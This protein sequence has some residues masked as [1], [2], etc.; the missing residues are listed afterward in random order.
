MARMRGDRWF[1]YPTREDYG[2]PA[3]LGISY[4]AVFFESEGRKLHGWFFAATTTTPKGTVIHCHGNGGNITGHFD[5]ISWMPAHGW[6]VLCFDYQG[7]GRSE[8][9]PSRPGTIV[10]A[11]AAIDYVKS[12][13]DVDE[14]RLVLSGQSLGGAVS[15]VVAAERDDLRGVAIEGAFS[16]Y[17]GAAYYVCKRSWLL[18][19]G[20]WPIS[21][22]LIAPGYDAIDYVARIA[23]TP[24]FFITGTDD[25][26]CDYRQTLELN[27]AAG[28]PKSL[29]VIDDGPHTGALTETNGEGQQKLDAFFTQ[30]VKA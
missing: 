8:G 10:D 6:N 5:Y 1:Y 13:A 27:E 16:S 9:R 28:Q 15:T 3:E 24:A 4:E 22:L 17:R 21:R 7:F 19:G 14:T 30:C 18:W 12:R 26:I 11:H 2:D 29:W 25:R 23:P 20:A